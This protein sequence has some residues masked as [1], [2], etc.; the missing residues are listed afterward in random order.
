M[1]SWEKL[2]K[3]DSYWAEHEDQGGI[4]GVIFFSVGGQV[5]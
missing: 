3:A 1:D 5:N 4:H 2:A